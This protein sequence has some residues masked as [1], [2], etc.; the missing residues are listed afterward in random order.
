MYF[1]SGTSHGAATNIG[2][3]EFIGYPQ[4]SFF[5][6]LEDSKVSWGVYFEDFPVVLDLDDVR[7]YPEKFKLMHD[8]FDDV[9]NNTLPT[10][11]F[12]EPRWHDY[13]NIFM[14]STQHPDHSISYGEFLLKEVYQS[15][16]SSSFWNETVF[17]VTYDEHGGCY[18]HVPPPDF[19]P[20]PDGMNSTKKGFEF[21]FSRLGLRIPFIVISPFVEQ[22]SVHHAPT[23]NHYEHTSV[24]KTVRKLLNMTI[25][26]PLTKREEW[27]AS[28]EHIFSFERKNNPSKLIPLPDNLQKQWTQY[29]K[30]RRIR[31]DDMHELEKLR[32]KK[33]YGENAF[34]TLNDL[35]IEVCQLAANVGKANV[36]LE[37]IE[38]WNQQEGSEFLKK[39]LSM[40]KKNS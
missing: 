38:K 1:H 27:A 7:I 21:D 18:D 22:G 23:K 17:I 5:K 36:S 15:L 33:A 31:P 26:R 13:F 28:F 32:K 3:H 30:S 29:Q 34:R 10:Y 37:E 9:K 40:W 35:Q 25:Q 6:D 19:A 14:A 24:M 39:M 2:S 12:L 11:S 8:F 16:R 20:N 4:R